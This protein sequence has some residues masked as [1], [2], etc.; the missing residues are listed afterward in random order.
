MSGVMA[1]KKIKNFEEALARL[2]AIVEQL[3]DGTV[4]LEESVEVFKEGI[5]AVEFSDCVNEKL[6]KAELELKKL[7]KNAEGDFLIETE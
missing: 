2:E 1:Q 7:V 3:E 4:S 6:D 5:E